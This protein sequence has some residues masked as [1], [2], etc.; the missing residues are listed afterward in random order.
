MIGTYD[1][2]N[3]EELINSSE[4]DITGSNRYEFD[5]AKPQDGQFVKI[6]VWDGTNSITPLSGVGTIGEKPVPT[7]EPTN[8]PTDKPVPTTDP[9]RTITVLSLI[10]I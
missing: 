5:Y 2:Q 3:Q 10:H 6:Y 1:S 8:A 7:I 4:Y 9:A